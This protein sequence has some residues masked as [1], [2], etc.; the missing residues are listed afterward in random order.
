M[1]S[2]NILSQDCSAQ[3]AWFQKTL[4]ATPKDDWVIVVGH[5]PADE[6]DVEDFASAMQKHGFDIYL[7]GHTHCLTQ[8]QIDG[9]GAYVTSGAGALVLSYDQMG[10]EADSTKFRNRTYHKA[11][12]LNLEEMETVAFGT[13]VTAGK[14]GHT[15][16][17]LFTAKKSGFT[18]HTFSADYKTLKTDFMGTDGSVL[19]SFSVTKGSGPT[20]GPP[21]PPSPPSPSPPPPSPSPSP[22]GSCCFYH[23]TSCLSGQTCCS[24]S[25]KS[26]ASES[27]SKKYGAVHHCKWTGSKCVAP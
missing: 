8:Y 18:L 24:G 11:N 10:G 27:S 4:A 21:T 13:N 15:Y 5:H 26:Y 7:N 25:G 1:F 20:P 16:K 17:Q 12:S 19:H 6:P 2:K 3:F 9:K 22:A 23:A 14:D